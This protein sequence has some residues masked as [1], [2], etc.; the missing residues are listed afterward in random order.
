MCCILLSLVFL[1][2]RA[3]VLVWWIYDP[4]RWERAFRTVLWPLLGLIFLPWTTLMY[5]IVE[6]GGIAWF[7]WLWLGIAFVLDLGMYSGSYYKREDVPGYS[8]YAGR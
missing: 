3:G 7:D 2:P 6:P 8:S 1:G 4:D 5:V